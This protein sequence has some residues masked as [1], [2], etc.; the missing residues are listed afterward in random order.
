MEKE[1]PCLATVKYKDGT[2]NPCCYP[3]KGTAYPLCS[4]H[5]KRRFKPSQLLCKQIDS[6]NFCRQIIK[7][8]KSDLALELE[9]KGYEWTDNSIKKT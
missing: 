2:I 3:V 4:R 5:Y 1:I 6:P 9:E 7:T 8:G